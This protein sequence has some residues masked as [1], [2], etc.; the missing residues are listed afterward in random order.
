MR[1]VA[2]VPIKLNNQ[3]LPG[4]N[5]LPLGGKPLCAHIFETL[6]KTP[7][8]DEVIAFCSDE[9]LK[10][11]LPN[12]VI[13]LKRDKELDGDLVKGLQ[14]YKA[15]LQEV[16]ADVYVLAHATSPFT[17]SATIDE[18]LQ[19]VISGKHDS[20]FSAKRIQ[21]FAWYEGRALNYQLTDIPRTQDIEPIFI[22]TSGFYIFKKEV[23]TKLGR[24][25]GRTPFIAETSDLEAIDIDEPSDYEMARR[26]IGDTDE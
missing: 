3:R 6:L 20:A 10:Q 24:R 15:F 2:F 13:F 9:S 17:Q 25:I 8:I 16:N 4:K 14:I 19:A 5:L 1:V 26:L 12:G 18:A 11:H 22:E 21:T 23:L 7:T